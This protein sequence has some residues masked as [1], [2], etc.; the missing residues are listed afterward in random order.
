MTREYLASLVC[1]F[2]AGFFIGG[3]V[4]LVPDNDW[5]RKLVYAVIAVVLISVG[6]LYSYVDGKQESKHESIHRS[7]VNR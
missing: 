3:V 4:S 5:N 2:A 7:L 1:R 6:N